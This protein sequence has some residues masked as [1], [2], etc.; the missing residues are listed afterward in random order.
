MEPAVGSSLAAGARDSCAR[1]RTLR[2]AAAG[3]GA[4]G[5]HSQPAAQRAAA[6]VTCEDCGVK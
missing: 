1:E 4:A 2:G 6:T 3:A 5:P